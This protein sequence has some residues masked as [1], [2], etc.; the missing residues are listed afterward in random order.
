[1]DKII[2]SAIS[3]RAV[4][5]TLAHE[6]LAP[7]K[8]MIHAE[9]YGD[10]RKA[11]KTDDFHDTFDYSAVEKSLIE[12]AENSSFQLLEALAESLAQTIL[13]EQTLVR[14]ILLRIDKPGAPLRAQCVSIEIR[15]DHS[16]S[17][18]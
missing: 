1:M 12:H 4:I 15:R 6:R 17:R 14:E 10:F 16:Q 9:L 18:K 7:Q 8:L 5:G 13:E 3:V 2:L 11:G